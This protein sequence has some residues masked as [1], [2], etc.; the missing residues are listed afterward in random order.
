MAREINPE[1]FGLNKQQFDDIK[2][3]FDEHDTDAT[4]TMQ[5]SEVGA[6]MRKLGQGVEDDDED[7]GTSIRNVD[8][9]NQG[10]IGLNEFLV[11]VTQSKLGEGEDG[12]EKQDTEPEAQDEEAKEEPQDE[13]Q[14]HAQVDEDVSQAQTYGDDRGN[15][16]QQSRVALAP[17]LA[18]EDQAVQDFL[19]ILDEHRRHCEREGKYL[20][21]ETASRRLKE[22]R[23]HEENRRREAMRSRQT[24]ERLGIE[25]AHMLEFEQFNAIWEQRMQEYE[26]SAEEGLEKLKEKHLA[27]IMAFQEEWQNKLPRKP[28]L[29]KELLNMRK[30]QD[31][32]AKQE[33][34]QEA[35]KIKFKA[36]ERE[37][38]ELARLQ[39]QLSQTLAAKEQRI[40]QKQHSELTGL[41]KRIQ[42]GREEYKK[43]R[44]CELERRLQR[45]KNVK[46]DLLSLIHISEPTRPY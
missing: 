31:T 15:Q 25:E 4:G 16:K 32:L 10:S 2:Q 14:D 36:D 40:R 26:K 22:L 44:H 19:R 30:I 41:A 42:R 28:K 46:D 24:A 1:D 23:Q 45:Y 37:A 38:W 35:Q 5:T 43:L 6:A 34:Y 33:R 17:E 20:E 13:P 18:A 12:P 9:E 21:A 27:E 11:V 7:L 39:D 3:V 8:P 29:S